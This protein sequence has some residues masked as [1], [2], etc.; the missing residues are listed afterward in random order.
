MDIGLLVLRIVVGL[1][2]AGHG[3]QKL[4][5]WFEGPALAGT[6][7]MME[8]LGYRPGRP[9]A[10]MAAL[11]EFVGG[12]L[13]LF[14]FLNPLG[15]I[16]VMAVMTTAIGRAHWGKPIWVTSGGGELPLTNFA[17][18]VAIGAAGPGLYSLDY[19]WGTS[20]PSSWALIAFVVVAIV[21]IAGIAASSQATHR[22]QAPA[23][24]AETERERVSEPVS[25][26]QQETR[27]DITES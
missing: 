12:L 21:T 14:G 15:P 5:G 2:V 1:L 4:F 10:L 7:G 16:G 22:P 9:W 23:Q 27:T 20:L 24:Q 8:S 19:A 3:A 6:T 25:L 11:G 13:M 17:V 18:A 26:R